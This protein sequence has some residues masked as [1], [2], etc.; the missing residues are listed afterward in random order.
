MEIRNLLENGVSVSEAA[1][2]LGVA[3][4][5]VRKY[6]DCLSFPP[7]VREKKRD[8]LEPY[9]DHIRKRLER[10][11]LS[12][13]RIY[14]EI[15]KMGYNGKLT[16]L[17]G[18]MRELR[19]EKAYHAVL[20]FETSP[21]QQAQVDWAYF[22]DIETGEGPK[23]LYCFLMILGHSRT[24]YI[25]FTTSMRLDVLIR[26]HINAFGYFG[27]A[28]R[29]I[30]YD[31]MKQ[32]VL[33][34]GPTVEESEFAPLYS[35]FAAFYG[36]KPRLCRVR[37]PR[38][39]GKVEN[40]VRYVRADFFLG[41]EFTSLEDLNMKSGAWMD[42]VNSQSHG[43]TGEIPFERLKTELGFL[44]DI[45]GKPEYRISEVLHRRARCNCLVSVYSAEYSVPPRYAN[46]EVEVRLDGDQLRIF[47]RGQEIAH[48]KKL[49]GGTSFIDAHRRELEEN[50]FQMPGQNRIR[51]KAEPIS[52]CGQAV[53]RRCLQA[54]E[55]D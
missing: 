33:R 51:R 14:D 41:L 31:N 32:V 17:R 29:E 28:P 44:T 54:Y 35:D 25:E 50:C 34:R 27:G 55:V 30:L 36:I 10:Y 24:R 39:K 52:I 13:M 1:R 15:Q 42:K 8:K 6:A 16:I 46:R 7:F 18:F 12:S 26:C 11:S 43:S 2:T 4:A 40:L 47:Y 20:M 53:E 37:K 48:H 5:T 22:G 45:K 21:G 19:H 3:R 23:H 49:D 38:T 9:K